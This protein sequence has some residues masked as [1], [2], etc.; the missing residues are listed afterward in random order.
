[1]T[2]LKIIEDDRVVA[3]TDKL[4]DHMASDISRS[5]CDKNG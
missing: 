5:T 2:F 3:L 1:M 4:L